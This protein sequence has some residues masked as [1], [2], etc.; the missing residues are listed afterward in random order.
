[1]SK[2]IHVVEDD[3]DIR[4]IIEF[5]LTDSNYEVSVS[6]TAKDFAESLPGNFPDLILLD[7]MLPDGDGRDIC[8]CLKSNNS[9]KDIPIIMMS[10]HAGEKEIA[11]KC[12]ANDFIKKPFD[13]EHF[14]T[15]INRLI[16]D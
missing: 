12:H 13:I 3:E 6:P 5:I 16:V 14:L 9:T 11:E 2:R 4:Y 8:R 10:A 1:M 7:I 15:S